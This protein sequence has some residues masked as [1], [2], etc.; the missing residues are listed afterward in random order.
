MLGKACVILLSAM[1]LI[2]TQFCKDN[3]SARK[4]TKKTVCLKLCKNRG[5]IKDDL[6]KVV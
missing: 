5:K 1:E 6:P 4:D 3:S 2:A